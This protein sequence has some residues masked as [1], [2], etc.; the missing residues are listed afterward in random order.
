MKIIFL[1]VWHGKM[2]EAL[3]AFIKEQAED[4]DV[5]CF[6]ECYPPAQALF[7]EILPD[8]PLVASAYKYISA[9]DDFAQATYVRRGKEAGRPQ[10]LFERE[11]LYCGLGVCVPVEFGDGILHVINF[12]GLA[13][14]G[15][16]TDD[17]NRIKQSKGLVDFCRASSAPKII[18]G[19]FNL[20]P[21]TQSVRMFSENGYHD[22]I[23]DFKI[24]TTRNRLAWEKYPGHEIYYS[25]FVFAGPKLK[26]TSFAA[27]QIEVSDHLPLVV[28]IEV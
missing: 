24:K 9:D 7:R 14:P 2:K 11:P 28:N 4:T 6:Q 13:Q 15:D 25:D 26:V 10:V 1:N 3:T 23:S 20:L 18:G 17:L 8:H 12:H 19:D 27:P 16:K 5:F 22:L 21:D